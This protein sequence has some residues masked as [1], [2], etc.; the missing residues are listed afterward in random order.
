VP[1]DIIEVGA[2]DLVPADCRLLEA[3]GLE[4]DESSL[5]GESLPVSK[6]PEPTSADM[7][8]ERTSMLYDTT[9]IAAGSAVAVVT[10]VGDSTEARRAIAAGARAPHGVGV[11][12][13]LEQLT[14]ITAP[15]AAAS[16]LAVVAAGLMRKRRAREL[17]SAGVSLTVAA[18]PEG[19]PLIATMAQLAAAGRLS[20]HRALVRNPRAVEALGRINVLC[21]DKTGTLTEG[22]IQLR[23]ISDGARSQTLDHLDDVH[24]A[25]LSAALRASPSSSNG[26]PLR[27]LTDR[28]LVEGADAIAVASD[29]GL[30]GW[31]R[32]DELPFEPSRGFHAG[33][34]RHTGGQV[35]SVKGAPEVLLP[36]CVRRRVEGREVA[37]GEQDRAALLEES[38]RLAGAGYRVLAVAEAEQQGDETVEGEDVQELAFRGFVAFADPVR[39]T[40]RAAVDDL[41]AAGV[42][43]VMITGDHPGTARAIAAELGLG[44]EP[45]TVTGP[46]LDRLDDADLDALIGEVAVFA[47]V[48]PMQKV[49]IV[50]AMQRTGKV[51][52]MTGDGANDAPAIRLADVGIALG[53]RST[54][55][56]RA[57][58]DLVV[59]DGRIETIVQAALEGRALW[60][61]VRDAVSVLVGGNLGEIS[62]TLLGGLLTGRSP[63]NA[64]QLLLVN[65]VTDTF[66]AL[67]IAL[68]P[69]AHKSPQQLRR[70]GPEASLGQPLTHDLAWRAAITAG[71][72][73]AAWL[74][75]RA[76]GSRAR[77][78]T[79]GMLTLTGTQLAQTLVLGGRNAPVLVAS[80]GSLAL[81]L[82]A[83]QTPGVSHF[84][85]CRPLGP[86]G[87]LC[88]S[89]ATAVGG[90]AAAWMRWQSPT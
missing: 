78:D 18:V 9:A 23:S 15:L 54:P 75:A 42:E 3:S 76:T 41:R 46:E 8:A 1:G 36:R 37:L 20:S 73:S 33:L 81:T 38:T 77:A 57:A 16:G 79:V 74:A 35:L 26:D 89:T 66:P 87:L 44:D 52:A 11:E 47:R 14:R 29:D 58:A 12:A 80:L 85:G 72:A 63:L 27:H 83:V 62:F 69:P 28:A 24:R 25:I 7:V 55:A 82:A 39:E 56:A 17:I 4:V 6:R 53:D 31:R 2:G 65:L 45:R 30:N 51:V 22:R 86:L 64:R 13:R 71:T 48:T 67:A 21:A 88:A 70:E 50:G 40:A 34:G 32:L 90:G 49:R 84:F 60:A 61:S 43:V 19:L 10:E 68:R 59:T 5:T